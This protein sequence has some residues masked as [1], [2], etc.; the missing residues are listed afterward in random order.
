[1][2]E[3]DIMTT[4]VKMTLDEFNE[5]KETREQPSKLLQQAYDNVK[6]KLDEAYKQID[7]LNASLATYI[8]GGAKP[9]E[10]PKLVEAAKNSRWSKAEKQTLHKYIGQSIKVLTEQLP[11][12]TEEAV[13]WQ[14]HQVD[15]HVSG[16]VVCKRPGYGK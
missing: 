11:G 1:M 8:I 2:D 4:Y 6:A 16:G 13:R 5:L 9:R 10:Q 15:L 3:G 7:E 12:R 14:L